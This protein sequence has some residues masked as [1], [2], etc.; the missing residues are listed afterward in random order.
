MLRLNW[1][2]A[3]GVLAF[4]NPLQLS[5]GVR[6]HTHPQTL[7]IQ[8]WD[9]ENHRS[10][11]SHFHPHAAAE[12]RVSADPPGSRPHL[13]GCWPSIRSHHR[14]TH[15]SCQKW[16]HVWTLRICFGVLGFWFDAKPLKYH[17]T[18]LQYWNWASPTS[19][20]LPTSWSC[21][22]FPLVIACQRL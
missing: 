9:P 13:S 15:R 20:P 6:H 11:P 8:H 5:S 10:A 12:W 7:M 3:A 16:R 4:E 19:L 2:V 22:S 21:R 14:R 17:T 18:W 1:S